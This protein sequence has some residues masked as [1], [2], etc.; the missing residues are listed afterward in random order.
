MLRFTLS[1]R[2]GN[3][4]NYNGHQYTKKRVNKSSQEWRC[5]DRKCTGTMSLC[6]LGITILREPSTHTCTLVSDSTII[7]EEAIDRMKIRAREE[8]TSITKIYS[9]EVVKTRIQYPDMATGLIF[10]SLYSIDAFLYRQRSKNYPMLPKSFL[11]LSLS[12]EWKLTTHEQRFLLIDEI[13]KSFLTSRSH[14]SM[15]LSY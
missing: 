15:H 6:T 4:C 7:M 10:P 8:T 14:F 1:E 3:I 5:R 12:E 13:C 2:G 11:D 9:Q